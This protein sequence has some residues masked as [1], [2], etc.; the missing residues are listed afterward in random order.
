MQPSDGCVPLFIL[1]VSAQWRVNNNLG[2]EQNNVV[3][4]KLEACPRPEKQKIEF[5]WLLSTHLGTRVDYL[6]RVALP[7]SRGRG[8]W[9]LR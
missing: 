3:F 8:S 1:R 4:I 7:F 5:W 9:R 6:M 2:D